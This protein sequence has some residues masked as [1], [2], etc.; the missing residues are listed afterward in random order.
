[1]NPAPQRG[2][3]GALIVRLRNWVG[4]V[5]LGLPV[6]AQLADAGY[7]L[8]LIGRPWAAGLLAGHGWP[9]HT[10]PR[11]TWAAVSQLAALKR[12]LTATDPLFPHRTNTLLLTTSL[13]SALEA[14]CAGLRAC[15]AAAEGRGPL[16]ARA[17]QLQTGLHVVESYWRVA[18]TLS[19]TGTP[20]ATTVLRT[21]PDHE[22]IARALL[23]SHQIHARYAV[24]CPFSGAGDTAGRRRWPGFTA[25]I[26]WL[27]EGGITPIICNAG[28]AE[29]DLARRDFPAAVIPD[30]MPLGAYAA[31]MRDA[32]CTIA[33]DTGP[34]HLA[35]IAGARLVSLYGP[36][37]FKTTWMPPEGPRATL[38]QNAARW[39]TVEEV[40]DQ[41]SAITSLDPVLDAT[42]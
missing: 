34:G 14:R 17:V 29:A 33:N 21:S 9:V 7:E 42:S 37:S 23:A 32:W 8:H 26:R 28:A 15:G 10:H 22:G 24:L 27:R 16:L 35:A 1:M 13:S 3:K 4:E 11:S 31:L 12:R 2:F 40:I 5:A 18:A 20:P 19:G 25:L 41:L 39:Q 30:P 36:E 6:L 38:L